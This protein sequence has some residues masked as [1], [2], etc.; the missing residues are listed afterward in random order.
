MP[1][2]FVLIAA[3][4]AQI[5][6]AGLAFRLNLRYRVYS[7][8]LL[9]SAAAFTMAA[10]R[11]STLM[12]LWTEPPTIEG[13]LLLWARTLTSLLG[14]LFL[15]AGLALIE[16]FFQQLARSQDS[17]QREHRKLQS[18]MQETEAELRLARS[19]QQNLLPKS[20]PSTGG[21]EV[22]GNSQPAEWTSGDYYDYVPLQDGTTAFIIADV[23]GHGLGPAMLASSVRAS[24]RALARTLDDVGEL[25]T[26]T[27]AAVSDAVSGRGFVTAFAARIDPD[28]CELH[29]AAAGH[30]AYLLRS[31]GTRQMLST[32]A[33]P[34]GVLAEVRLAKHCHP[35]LES[36]DILILVTDGILETTDAQGNMFGDSHLFD[37]V[38]QLHSSCAAEIVVG[39]F[40]A[41]HQFGGRKPQ[42]DDN[43]AV[44]I[45]VP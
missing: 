10:L 23:S 21:L 4:V 37:S 44:I 14:S 25:L 35:A 36:G 12:D 1:Y 22:A 39:L 15:V 29:Y 17:L 40:A 8:W 24:I 45:K 11:F 3:L 13:N 2:K 32:D 19:I 30:T 9:I 7:A 34:M 26:Q 42:R 16:P 18:V 43:T 31:D 33:P 41:A 5:V 38:A 6:A 27:N 28:T 20:S